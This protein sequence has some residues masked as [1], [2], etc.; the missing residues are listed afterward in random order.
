M[1]L[2]K[3]GSLAEASC[4]AAGGIVKHE[5][6]Q[7]RTPN[8]SQ[9]AAAPRRIWIGR[10]LVGFMMRILGTVGERGVSPARLSHCR[11]PGNSKPAGKKINLSGRFPEQPASWP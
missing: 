10:L 11:S 3:L 6:E 8:Q 5:W 4:A 9:Q 1:S 2:S 7:I